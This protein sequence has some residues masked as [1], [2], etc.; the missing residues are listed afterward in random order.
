M[1]HISTP[2]PASSAAAPSPNDAARRDRTLAASNAPGYDDVVR[3]ARASRLRFARRCSPAG[4]KSV[5]NHVYGGL[6]NRNP[7]E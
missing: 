5:S 7:D 1:P 4:G 2:T 3:P 6:R